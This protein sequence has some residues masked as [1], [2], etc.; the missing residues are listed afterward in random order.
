MSDVNKNKLFNYIIQAHE[1][2]TNIKT[3]I[4]LKHYLL[5]RKSKLVLYGYD[6]FLFDIHKD[7]RVQVFR[8]LKQILERNGNLV[9]AKAGKNY[10]EMVNITEKI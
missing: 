6:S 2:E 3:I 10:G 1:T 8:E 5:N 4:D 9:K 7:D